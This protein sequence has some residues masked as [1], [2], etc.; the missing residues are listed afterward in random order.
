M[1]RN[2]LHLSSFLLKVESMLADWP[3]Y[4]ETNPFSVCTFITPE[5]KITAY[6]WVTGIVPSTIHH[7]YADFYAV[8]S[9]N[10]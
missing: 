1:L 8:S 4:C 9:S 7:W 5:V 3:K 2:K 10:A 6:K